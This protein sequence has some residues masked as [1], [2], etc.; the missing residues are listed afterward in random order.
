VVRSTPAR[1][2]GGT[3]RKLVSAYAERLEEEEAGGP[4][5]GR[6]SVYQLADL[7]VDAPSRSAAT[8]KSLR[9][10]LGGKPGVMSAAL[11]KDNPAGGGRGFSRGRARELKNDRS[12][13]PNRITNIVQVDESPGPTGRYAAATGA[14]SARSGCYGQADAPLT[15]SQICRWKGGGQQGF[16]PRLS[17]GCSLEQFPAGLT[18]GIAGYG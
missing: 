2:Q 16:Q 13:N 9:T 17:G 18:A 4:A 7:T 6:K 14:M 11:R 8:Q 15:G 12:R 5:R 10:A 3:G 1:D